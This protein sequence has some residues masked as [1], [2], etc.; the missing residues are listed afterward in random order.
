MP[1]GSGRCTAGEGQRGTALIQ[2]ALG[3]VDRKSVETFLPEP[4]SARWVAIFLQGAVD[5]WRQHLFHF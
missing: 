4:S 1:I 3:G 5:V 2:N